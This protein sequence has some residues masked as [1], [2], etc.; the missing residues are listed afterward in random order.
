MTGAG[1]VLSVALAHVATNFDNM[2]LLFALM[3]SLGPRRAAGGFAGS[4]LVA[5][6]AALLLGGGGGAA[7]PAGWISW[8]GLV[9]IGLGLRGLWTNLRPGSAEAKL[10]RAPASFL[11]TLLLFLSL[12]SD[13]FVVMTALFADS[14]ATY[15]PAVFA[16]GLASIAGL[17]A[18]AFLLARVAARAAA[19]VRRLETLGPVA[20][21]LAG[22]YVLLDTATDVA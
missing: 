16:G 1:F 9:P 11:L 13:S 17:S 18:A 15:D 3:P 5:L 19:L 14:S 20:M 7:L 12:T 6:L 8:L 4:Q 22:L 21:I 10:G 2:A